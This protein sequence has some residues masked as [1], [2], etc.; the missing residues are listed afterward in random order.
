MRRVSILSLRVIPLIAVAISVA[1]VLFGI[2][3]SATSDVLRAIGEPFVLLV[4]YGILV[5]GAL[6][7]WNLA[8]QVALEPAT[9]L[10][11]ISAAVITLFVTLGDLGLRS[12]TIGGSVALL[13][14]FAL[15]SLAGYRGALRGGNA[16]SGLLAGCWSG[17][18]CA[19]VKV[20]FSLALLYSSIPRPELVATWPEFRSGGWHDMH[21]WLAYRAMNAAGQ[22]LM[23]GPVLGAAFGLAGGIVARMRLRFVPELIG[24]CALLAIVILGAIFPGQILGQTQP[25]F[26]VASIKLSELASAT[27]I[28]TTGGRF[29]GTATLRTL[30]RTAW[31]VQDFQ[32]QGVPGWGNT[33]LYDVAASAEDASANSQLML[34]ALLA[35][36]FTLTLHHEMRDVPGYVL[37]IAKNGSKL[38]TASDDQGAP[39]EDLRIARRPGAATTQLSATRTPLLHFAAALSSMLGMP[40]A[41]GT[42]LA[43][44][45]DFQLEWAMDQ[46]VSPATQELSGPSVFTAL[47]DQLGLRLESGRAQSDVLVIDHVERPS[48]N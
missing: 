20:A 30:I 3:P 23:E 43:G 8:R 40:V 11:L 34:Q 31:H 33:Q 26:D 9:H 45:F 47:Q 46:T 44:A 24:A 32:I 48:E 29:S 14:I 16:G 1:V 6:M 38:R 22:H 39:P 41:D 12:G 42:G 36:R 7:N 25:V 28:R 17:M 27:A 37:S 10:G 21:A 4:M 35:D 19:M 2:K 18:V 15:W 13:V 5:L